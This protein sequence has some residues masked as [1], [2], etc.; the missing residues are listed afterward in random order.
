MI[1]LILQAKIQEADVINSKGK[2]LVLGAWGRFGR[3][4]VTAFADAGWQ[5]TAAGR[6]RDDEPALGQVDRLVL[7]AFDPASVVQAVSGQ[8]VIVNALNPPYPQWSVDLP[9]LTRSVIA[10]AGENGAT[11]MVPGNV[12]N[13]GQGMPAVLNEATP[14]RPSTKKGRLR[15]EMEQSYADAAGAN[16]ANDGVQT[17]ILRAGDFLEG[18]RTGNWFDSIIAKDVSKGCVT[19]PGAADI[20]HAWAYLPDMARAMVGLAEK[21]DQLGRFECIGFEGF[22]LTGNDLVG[23]MEQAAGRSLRRKNLPWW[24][25]AMVALVSPMIREVQEMRYLWQ[26]PHQIDS[27][28]LHAVL[29]DFRPTAPDQAMRQ[30]LTALAA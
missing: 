4:A 28:R 17:I 2:V 6:F 30:M 15:V 26:V 3:A 29:P 27:T 23:L 22:T 18:A 24:I 20:P 16:G 11:V 25:L 21:R 8:H 12:Y 7:D 14:A 9:R 13:Y 19:L 10:A 1:I 5:V